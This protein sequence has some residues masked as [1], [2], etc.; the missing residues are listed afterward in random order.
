MI[1]SS[2]QSLID[3]VGQKISSLM[4]AQA[5]YSRQLAPDFNTFDYINTDELGLSRILA[6]L[7]NQQGSHAQKANFLHLFI[8]HCLPCI[9]NDVHWQPFIAGLEQTKVT[10][11]ETTRASE[12]FRRMDIYIQGQVGADSF[13]ICIE[14]KPYA[15]D[16]FKQL[17]DY[18]SE[19][20]NRRLTQWHI[21]YLNESENGPCEHSVDK[22]TLDRWIMNNKYSHLRFSDLINWLKACQS[23]CQNHSVAEFLAQFIKFIQKQFMGVEDMNEAQSVLE[24]MLSSQENI[25]SALKIALSTHDMKKQLIEKLQRDLMAI[26]EDKSKPY[27]MI[28]TD[29]KGVNREE[30]IVFNIKESALELRLGFGGTVFNNHYLGIFIA[31]SDVVSDYEY[32]EKILTKCKAGDSMADKN[33]KAEADKSKGGYWCAWYSFEPH[34]WWSNTEPWEQIHNGEMAHEIIKELD[35]YY[36]VL[37]DDNLLSK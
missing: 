22:R 10:I 16:Q 34:D 3:E 36:K 9:Y 1:M 11:E 13:G 32:Y 15:S 31:N 6:D 17:E 12:T 25:A 28:K 7:L 19:L 5:L 14:N 30:Q 4:T 20:E 27:S 35:E 21:V 26:I 29:L 8:Q 18:A 23:D 33:I 2:V 37:K 24:T